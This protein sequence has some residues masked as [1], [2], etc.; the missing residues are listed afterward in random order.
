MCECGLGMPRA[1]LPGEHGGHL[2]VW[3]A[4]PATAAVS[5]RWEEASAWPFIASSLENS[6]VSGPGMGPSVMSLHS[7]LYSVAFGVMYQGSLFQGGWV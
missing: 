3:W 5:D 6:A 7:W 1:S 4:E 2:E